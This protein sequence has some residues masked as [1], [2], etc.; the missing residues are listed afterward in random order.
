MCGRYLLGFSAGD[1]LRCFGVGAPEGFTPRFNAAPTQQLPILRLNQGVFQASF[2][3]WG[4]IPFW[5]KDASIGARMINARSES[6]GSKPSFRQALRSRRCLVPAEGFYEWSGP[7]GGKIPWLIRRGDFLTFGG[8]WERWGGPEHEIESFT[9][10]TTQANAAV[11]HLHDRMP[12][13]IEKSEWEDWLDPGRTTA[14]ELQ[15]YFEPA[16]PEGFEIVRVSPVVN[17]ARNDSPECSQPLG[18]V[19]RVGPRP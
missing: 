18:G 17:S 19:L 1:F 6:A 9:I 14:Q 7:K 8:L 4:L 15:D 2:A 10:L 16:S 11:E 12:V 3:K 13:I 5:A